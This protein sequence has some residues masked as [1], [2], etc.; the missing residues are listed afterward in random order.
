M[1]KAYLGLVKCDRPYITSSSAYCGG[2]S[3]RENSPF[4][5][6]YFNCTVFAGCSS[7]ET[8]RCKSSRALLTS[9]ATSAGVILSL[10]QETWMVK[11]EDLERNEFK[12]NL[13]QK[14]RNSYVTYTGA[15][16]FGSILRLNGCTSLISR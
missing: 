7:S 9:L 8:C 13:R 5:S 10:S 16:T 4:P 6:L 15:E 1:L 3:R 12:C 2:V 11:Q 14:Q